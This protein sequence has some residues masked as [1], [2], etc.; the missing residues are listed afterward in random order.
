LDTS[1]DTT[2]TARP[3]R[4][5]CAY[6]P[7]WLSGPTPGYRGLVATVDRDDVDAEAGDRHPAG[8]R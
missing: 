8:T 1:P 3:A 6:S 7:T 2:S 5:L 4:L